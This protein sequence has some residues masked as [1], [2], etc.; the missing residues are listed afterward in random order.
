M[1]NKA[2]RRGL[3]ALTDAGLIGEE[4]LIPAVASAIDGGAVMVQY[5]DKSGD[6]AKCLWEAQDLRHLCRALRT[7]LIINDDVA[8]A[9]E[10]GA[11]GV[12]LGRDDAD[13][14]AARAVLGPEAIIGVSCYNSLEL[15]VAAEQAGADY[16]A[17]GSFFS[18]GIKPDAVRAT[19]ELLR[20]A[21]AQL[22]L[23]VV[24]IGGITADNGAQ[25]VAAGADL[26]A[27][28]SDVFGQADIRAAAR[29]ITELFE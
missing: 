5:R 24:A 14:A 7:P 9:R 26:L 8:L 27:V 1:T 22:R 21:K 6:A 17:F 25:L 10:V 28:I 12:H 4:R 2:I 20:Q 16:V 29:R 13:I 3:Y 18:S 11:D 15:A 19:P 23:P